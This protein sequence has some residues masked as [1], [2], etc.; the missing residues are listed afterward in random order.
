ML[1]TPHILRL[2]SALMLLWISQPLFAGGE[3]KKSPIFDRI[4]VIY[5]APENLGELSLEEL[6][7]EKAL[8]V[9]DLKAIKEASDEP[10]VAKQ[11]LLETILEHDDRRLQIAEIIP[12]LIADYQIEGEFRDS[13]LNYSKTFNV[14]MR[15]ARKHV[16][17]LNDYKSYDFRFSAVYM[18][19]M[20]AFRE[21]PEFHKRLLKDLSNEDTAIGKY[22]KELDESYA[23]VG[24]DKQLIQNIYSIGELE[25]T[26]TTIDQEIL[27]RTHKEM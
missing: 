23:Q 22:R 9:R 2:V 19:M 6:L 17:T 16:K 20:F 5:K 1:K 21:N 27:R 11:K 4:E 7:A 10:D 24:R 13:L 25:Q 26:I 12:Q 15:A 18:S 3:V 14:E 8:H